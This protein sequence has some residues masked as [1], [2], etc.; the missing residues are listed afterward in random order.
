MSAF[1]RAS[2]SRGLEA[3]Q[4][5]IGAQEEQL[6]DAEA[7][8]SPQSGSGKVSR[9]MKQRLSF[10]KESSLDSVKYANVTIAEGDDEAG[11]SIISSSSSDSNRG[12][13]NRGPPIISPALLAAAAGA[14][15][16]SAVPTSDSASDK[17]ASSSTTVTG[18][19]E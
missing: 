14:G 1:R 18:C 15:M 10:K 9:T 8:A 7:A 6:D 11:S 5:L 2:I 12:D 13:A 16:K 19:A 4:A 17:S 3:M